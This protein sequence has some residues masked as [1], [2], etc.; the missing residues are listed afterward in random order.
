M[1]PSYTV[2]YQLHKWVASLSLKGV[3]KGVLRVLADHADW[4]DYTCYP[5]A[6]CIAHISGFCKWAVQRAIRRL[7]EQEVIEC[8]FSAG[9]NPNRYRLRV[10]SVP[11]TPFR[12]ANSV[13]DT[14]FGV[15]NRLLDTRQPCV[16][17][18][19]NRVLDTPE[20]DNL[21]RNTNKNAQRQRAA[22]R[23]C[24]FDIFYGAYPKKRD[25]AD[26][27]GPVSRFWHN[28][29]Y[30]QGDFAQVRLPAVVSID[31]HAISRDSDWGKVIKLRSCANPIGETRLACSTTDPTM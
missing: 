16:S 5:S 26:R 9:R 17:H 19:P 15:A 7:I 30:R 24:A 11:D 6:D 22:A 14:P 3:E 29:R 13:P 25:R 23:V 20:Q 2:F 28:H 1:P 27:G 21:T 31:Q 4:T 8:E 12:T 18:I 10:N